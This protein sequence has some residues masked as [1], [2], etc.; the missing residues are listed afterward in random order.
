M[1]QT[2]QVQ[3]SPIIFEKKRQDMFLVFKNGKIITYK[4]ITP[5]KT[6]TY[7]GTSFLTFDGTLDNGSRAN[8][9]FQIIEAMI[10]EITDTEQGH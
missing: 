6:K 2:E 8:I 3:N 10:I 9:T 4:N 7:N 5:P 1:E